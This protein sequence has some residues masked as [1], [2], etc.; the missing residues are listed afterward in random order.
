MSWPSTRLLY[1]CAF[2]PK[3]VPTFVAERLHAWALKKITGAP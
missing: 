2:P 3:W 1:W